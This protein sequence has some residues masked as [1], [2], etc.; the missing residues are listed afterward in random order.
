MKRFL[1][2]YHSHPAPPF[3]TTVVDVHAKCVLSALRDAK[4][5]IKLQHDWQ[6]AQAV[7][8]PRGCVDVDEAARRV[9]SR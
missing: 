4:R 5:E 6:F 8:W 7:P 1:V 2:I 3:D 9:A